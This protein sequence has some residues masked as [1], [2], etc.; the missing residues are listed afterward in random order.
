[1]RTDRG[2]YV[3]KSSP[4]LK[5]VVGT[6]KSQAAAPPNKASST[7]AS[8]FTRAGQATTD[9]RRE[10]GGDARGAA[11]EAGEAVSGQPP[12]Q[13]VG[14]RGQGG[15]ARLIAQ[16]GQV[17]EDGGRVDR[18]QAHPVGKALDEAFAEDV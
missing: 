18:V 3:F 13:A 4:A 6:S 14:E 7:G 11:Q 9:G 1:M 16:Q 12:H 2:M 5:N 10:R 15:R 8:V 17:P